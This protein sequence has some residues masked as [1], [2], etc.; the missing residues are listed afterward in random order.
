MKTRHIFSRPLIE[1]VLL[2]PNAALRWVAITVV[3]APLLAPMPS[4]AR[5]DPLDANAPVPPL[6]RQ[7]SLSTPLPLGEAAVGSWRDA[8]DTVNRIGGWRAYAREAPR[9]PAS[10]TLQAPVP[11]A[12]QNAQPAAPMRSPSET[13][14]PPHGRH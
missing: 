9:S 4:E 11:A 1:C 10:S 2:A 13:A 5:P 12:P 6:S 14:S 8:N 3:M 7:S